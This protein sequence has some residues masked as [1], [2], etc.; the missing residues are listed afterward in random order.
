LKSLKSLLLPPPGYKDE[1]KFYELAAGPPNSRAPFV[2]YGDFETTVDVSDPIDNVTVVGDNWLRRG[3]LLRLNV[4]CLGSGPWTY[5]THAHDGPYNV[6]GQETCVVPLTLYVCEFRLVHYFPGA[7]AYTMVI[8]L[9]NGIS[10][11]VKS[12]AVNVYDG[13]KAI[14]SIGVVCKSVWLRW[15]C[16]LWK[17]EETFHGGDRNISFGLRDQPRRVRCSRCQLLL[18]L[19]LSCVHC[20]MYSAR[21]SLLQ[22]IRFQLL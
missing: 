22:K 10:K 7:G 2:L 19:E 4:S 1:E 14:F 13:K 17:K 3:S 21:I 11:T 6:T 8:V 20:V 9:K 16:K 12:I 5:C 15:S 18:I